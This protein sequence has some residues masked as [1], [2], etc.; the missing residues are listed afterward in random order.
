MRPEEEEDLRFFAAIGRCVT[1]W[2]HVEDELA[3]VYMEAIGAPLSAPAFAAFYAVQSPEVKISIVNSAVSLRLQEGPMLN[4]WKG[5]Y[6]RA[7]K[8]RKTRNSIAHYQVTVDPRL[9]IGRRYRLQPPIKDIN[10]IA[11]YGTNLRIGYPVYCQETLEAAARAFGALSWGLKEYAY[12][13]GRHLGQ[14]EPEPSLDQCLD[15]ELR[16]LADRSTTD[17]ALPSEWPRRPASDAPQST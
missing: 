15:S 6:N 11:K 12:V 5:F 9:K 4:R 7:S 17:S 1:A 14:R 16:H 10:N 3:A 13:L 8:R 2:S